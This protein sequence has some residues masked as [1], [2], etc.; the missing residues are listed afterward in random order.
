MY[1]NDSFIFFANYIV[2]LNQS[3]LVLFTMKSDVCDNINI[4]AI[5]IISQAYV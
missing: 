5:F 1:I 2:N 4:S 3:S